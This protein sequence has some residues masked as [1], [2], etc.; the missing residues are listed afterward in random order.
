MGK[1]SPEICCVLYFSPTRF[2]KRQNGPEPST[3]WP[4]LTTHS[5]PVA[6]L[7]LEQRVSELRLYKRGAGR[8]GGVSRTFKHQ[9]GR[10]APVFGKAVSFRHYLVSGPNLLFRLYAAHKHYPPVPVTRQVRAGTL[11]ALKRVREPATCEVTKN[12]PSSAKAIPAGPEMASFPRFRWL[13]A[14]AATPTNWP[15]GAKR[16]TWLSLY[17]ATYMSPS[18]PHVIP[19]GPRTTP[20]A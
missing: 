14:P 4:A 13:V 19:T 7:L 10:Q 5:G 9:G 20:L 6:K 1:L 8:R 11:V 15:L 16:S 17:E 3:W 2:R 12:V 18:G